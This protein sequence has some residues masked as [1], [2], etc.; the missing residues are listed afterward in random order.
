MSKQVLVVAA[1]PDDETI[2]MGG[3]ID[4]HSTLGHTVHVIFLAS[5]VDSRGPDR[6]AARRRGGAAEA[7]CRIL[8]AVILGFCELSD[9]GFLSV[10]LLS[11][12]RANE[13]VKGR[14]DS[15]IVYTHHGGDP[16]IDHCR[17][18]QAVLT[19]FRPQPGETCQ[20]IRSLEVSSATERAHPSIGAPFALDTFI[21]IEDYRKQLLA[22]YLC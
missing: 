20:E 7:A 10:S 1:R 3:T 13:E 5:G 6:E 9:N 17:T 12:V 19:A 15:D 11:I 4:R 2:G 8:G 21:D 22:A 16:N 18:C 14:F